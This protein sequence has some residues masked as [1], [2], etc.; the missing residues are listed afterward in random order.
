MMG[1]SRDFNIIYSENYDAVLFL[2]KQKINNDMVC[3]EIANDVFLKV[4]KALKRFD[5]KVKTRTWLFVIT[6]NTIIDY[7]RRQKTTLKTDYGKLESDTKLTTNNSPDEIL[8]NKEI[9]NDIMDVINGLNP[10]LKTIAIRYFLNQEKYSVIAEDL[11]I[12]LGTLKTSIFRCRK[13]LQESLFE[14]SVR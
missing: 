9:N 14:Y 12:P 4:N 5:F 10:K 13:L 1:E 3:E 7:Y 11:N 6:R 8:N 2:I